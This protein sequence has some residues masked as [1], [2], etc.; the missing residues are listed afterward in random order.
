LKG[1]RATQQLSDLKG[2]R[3]RQHDACF[4]DGGALIM[5]S[6]ID[7][8]ATRDRFSNRHI[9]ASQPP[10]AK[11]ASSTTQG[12]TTK[13][14]VPHVTKNGGKGS[15]TVFD[16]VLSVSQHDISLTMRS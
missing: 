16:Y 13:S 9:L 10:D 6:K 11:L 14:L 1:R 7:G 5:P 4:F 15:R 2:F 3:F 8:R 12:K